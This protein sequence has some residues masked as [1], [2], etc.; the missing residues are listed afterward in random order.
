MTKSQLLIL[1]SES[2][3]LRGLAAKLCNYRDIQHDLYQEFLLFLCE[4]PEEFLLNKY[5]N[6]Q[7]IHYCYNCVHGLNSR[8]LKANQLINSKCPLVERHNIHEIIDF[9]I[10]ENIYNF[11]VEEQIDK[12][13]KFAKEDKFKVEVLFK[14]VVTS[15]R[16]IAQDLGVNQR[17]LIYQNNLFKKELRTKLR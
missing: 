12:I 8:R 17:K 11:E 4:K 5:D 1:A 14:S 7:F 9:D 16:Q 13:V 3:I 6:A 15:T 10:E 2:K